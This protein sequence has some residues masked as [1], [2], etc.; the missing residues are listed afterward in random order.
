MAFLIMHGM[1][2]RFPLLTEQSA[3]SVRFR[4]Q[5]SFQ[6]GHR[7]HT[8]GTLRKNHSPS[9]APSTLLGVSRTRYSSEPACLQVPVTRK[10]QLLFLFSCI[11]T[12]LYVLQLSELA[13]EHEVPTCATFS[14]MGVATV[15]CAY[16]STHTH[17]SVF[18]LPSCTWNGPCAC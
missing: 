12:L 9:T 11:V 2:L 14:L 1:V 16:P 13:H 17:L 4:P 18:F 6:V 15:Q 3:D 5:V 10:V 7:L 8:R